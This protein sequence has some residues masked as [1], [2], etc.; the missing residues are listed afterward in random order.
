MKFDL[1][2]PNLSDIFDIHV[3]YLY[4]KLKKKTIGM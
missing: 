4:N 3:Q 1:H 2:I